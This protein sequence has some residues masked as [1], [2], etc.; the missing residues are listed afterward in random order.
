[1][2]N[3]AKGLTDYEV[4]GNENMDEEDIAILDDEE[5][6]EENCE[7]NFVS[8]VESIEEEKEKGEKATEKI[9][10]KLE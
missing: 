1:M 3:I 4:E 2:V 6:E 10:V 9:K 5:E 8:D 7:N